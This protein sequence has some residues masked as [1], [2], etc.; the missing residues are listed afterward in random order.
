MSTLR[1][2]SIGSQ[3]KPTSSSIYRFQTQFIINNDNVGGKTLNTTS[4]EEVASDMRISITPSYIDSLI[5]I[6]YHFLFGGGNSTLVRHFKI[7]NVT[8]STDVDLGHSAQGNR[9]NMHGSH[10]NQD[11]DD[12]DVDMLTVEASEISGSTTER[13]YGLFFKLESGSDDSYFNHTTTDTASIGYVKPMITIQ[14]M[15]K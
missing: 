9:T 7:R 3:E 11:A 1:V 14:E 10:R 15:S 13:T 8:T 6:K 2:N 5:L 12:N 4:F